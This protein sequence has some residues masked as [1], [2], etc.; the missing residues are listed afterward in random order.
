MADSRFPPGGRRGFGSPF[1]H[2]VWGIDATEYIQSANEHVVVMIQIETQ[3]A[4]QN[5][6]AIAA[7]DGIGELGV[8]NCAHR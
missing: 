7:V 3:E 1:T 5:V 4:V 8:G 2:G 6:E